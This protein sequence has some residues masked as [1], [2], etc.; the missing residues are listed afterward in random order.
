[1]TALR[2][3]KWILGKIADSSG[4]RCA[5]NA[6]ARLGHFRKDRWDVAHDSTTI[7]A[8]VSSHAGA[9]RD[10]RGAGI[11]AGYLLVPWTDSGPARL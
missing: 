1:M 3:S 8:G 5:M 9:G 2:V 10:K 4:T 7:N 11:R 6:T